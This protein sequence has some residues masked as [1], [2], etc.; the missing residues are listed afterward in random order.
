MA[1][2]DYYATL[3][4]PPEASPEAIRLAY[5]RLA[6]QYHP[7]RSTAQDA[8]ERFKAINEA[9]EVLGDVARR[10]AYDQMR[11]EVQGSPE[12]GRATRRGFDE[13]LS[14]FTAMRDKARDPAWSETLRGFFNDAGLARA[15]RGEDQHGTLALSLE[16]MARGA[17]RECSVRVN[18]LDDDGIAHVVEKR[19]KVRI[20]AGIT[21]G[22][23]I[24]LAGMGGEGDPAGDLLLTIELIPHPHFT[25][26]G[27]D[28]LLRL[29]LAPWEAALGAN[30]QV[31]TPHGPVQLKIPA[32]SQSGKRLRLPGKGLPGKPAG[33]L[34]VEL[35]IH[36]PPAL[37]A[38]ARAFYQEMAMS[39][40]FNPRAEWG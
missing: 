7:D 18:A 8:E 9:H 37:T 33:D 2:K 40:P 13:I 29:P 32:A 14:R 12:L 10:A 31:P 17:H 34:L 1:F 6:S 30:L 27:R 26:D 15:R 35:Q 24:R 38:E 23:R 21:P 20:P 19:V 16:D 11:R 25:L 36:V 4:L 5:R 28:V 22:K 39:L 3:G